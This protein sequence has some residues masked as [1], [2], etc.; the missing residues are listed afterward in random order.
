MDI[1]IL[2]EVKKIL[3]GDR[4]REYG[5]PDKSL[6]TIAKLWTTYIHTSLDVDL[7]ITPSD[8]CMMMVLLK[9]ARQSNSKDRDSYRDIIGYS[10][11]AGDL[12]HKEIKIDH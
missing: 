8:V 1:P 5:S 12:L 9:V 6:E 10:A 2:D 3:N 7:K 11:I 4:Q